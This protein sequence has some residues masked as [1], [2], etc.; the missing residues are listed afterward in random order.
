LRWLKFIRQNPLPV[1][2]RTP[3]QFEMPHCRSL[4]ERIRQILEYGVHLAV[5]DGLPLDEM[6]VDEAK[7]LGW[8][9]CAML[10][11]LVPQKWDGKMIYDV[12]DEGTPYTIGVRT[13]VTNVGLDFHTDT[14]FN[15]CVT[16]Y[17]VLLCLQPAPIGGLSRA[18]NLATVHNLIR[19]RFKHHLH[20]L[21]EPFYFD[22]QMEHAPNEPRSR[23]YPI[24]TFDDQL[25]VRC[26]A[27]LIRNGY[28]LA[29]EALDEA[30]DAA[31]ATFQ[32]VL[33]D[34]SL[35]WEDKLQRGQMQFINNFDIAHTRTAFQDADDPASKRHLVR[36]WVRD[37]GPIFFL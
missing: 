22:R 28:Y 2:L 21:Y 25:R 34:D 20:R 9:L 27:T 35:W 19:E 3:D 37:E 12:R 30:S 14:P 5:L 4:L 23:Q 29:G 31:L 1:L 17:V 32:D 11:R 26:N 13:S 18:L 7:A 36:Y 16:K 6:D 33:S 15:D 24:F 10:G 8:V